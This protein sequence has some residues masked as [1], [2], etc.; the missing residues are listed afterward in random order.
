[1]SRVA[2]AARGAGGTPR[3]GRSGRR[4]AAAT[5][6]L[7][8]RRPALGRWG[9]ALLLALAALLM[10]PVVHALFGDAGVLLFGGLGLGFLLGRWTGK[11]RA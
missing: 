11:P 6:S 10:L 5:L 7:W 8:R 3:R 1:M 4:G 9:A 2:P